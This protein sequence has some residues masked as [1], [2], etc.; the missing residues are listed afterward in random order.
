VAAVGSLSYNDFNK[1][2][3]EGEKEASTLQKTR[4]HL[5]VNLTKRK[6]DKK[7]EKRQDQKNPKPTACPKRMPRPSPHPANPQFW[8]YQKFQ[9]S[10]NEQSCCMI[11]PTKQKKM[12]N[13][14]NNDIQDALMAHH[15]LKRSTDLPLFYADKSKDTTTGHQLIGWVDIA[16]NIATWDDKRKG[17]KLARIL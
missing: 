2:K 3:S 1:R 14:L 11:K 8:K 10:H 15:C 5:V 13:P 7:D 16:T 12:A 6:V 4:S 9:Q 17:H